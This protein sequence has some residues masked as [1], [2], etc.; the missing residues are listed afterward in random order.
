[1]AQLAARFPAGIRWDLPYDTTD[2]VRESIHEVLITLGIAILL[3]V[4]VIFSFLTGLA[5]DAYSGADYS[6]LPDR[7]VRSGFGLA[8]F[9]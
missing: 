8:F 1:M 9:D 5:H 3:V 4:V 6:R 2:F 7:H